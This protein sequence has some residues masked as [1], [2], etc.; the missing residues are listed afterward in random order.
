MPS[1]RAVLCGRSTRRERSRRSWELCSRVLKHLS[2]ANQLSSRSCYCGTMSPG[3][4]SPPATRRARLGELARRL[5]SVSSWIGRHLDAHFEALG[6]TP[7]VAR[8]LLQ[9][10]P[11][12]PIPTRQLAERLCCDPSNVTVFVDRLEELGLVERRVDPGDRRVKTLAM[13]SAGR[14]VRN[15]LNTIIAGNTPPFR[16]LTVDEQ[17]TLLALLEKAW[18]ACEE[19]DRDSRRS[20]PHRPGAGRVRSSRTPRRA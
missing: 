6:L 7:A 12:T 11:G 4:P 2:G 10:E 13:T 17:L 14:R 8:A 16:G 9:L 15:Q 1:G 19:H 20:V 5:M 3:S 18:A